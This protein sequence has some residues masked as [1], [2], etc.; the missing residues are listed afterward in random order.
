[1]VRGLPGSGKSTL[2]SYLHQGIQ[3]ST[4]GFVAWVET[5]DYFMVDGE[6]RFNP[7]QL[8]DAH[9]WCQKEVRN[10]MQEDFENIIVSN[11]FSQM[12][13]IEPYTCM[14]QA[15]GY[16][17]QILECKG[18]FGSDHNVPQATIDRMTQR[19]EQV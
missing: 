8:G 1:M 3:K 6:Y 13:E 10:A 16:N 11:T 18:K 2:A 4:R 12:W 15:F 19:W 9:D 7:Q 5:D 17:V 14:A